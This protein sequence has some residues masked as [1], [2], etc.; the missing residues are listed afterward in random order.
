MINTNLQQKIEILNNHKCFAS[1]DSIKELKRFMSW[2]V[3]AVWDF[4][5]LLKRLQRDFTCV[6]IPWI[7]SGNPDMGRLISEIAIEEEFDVFSK[8]KHLSHFEIYLKGMKEIGADTSFIEEFILHI[9]NKI[10]TSEAL[11]LSNTPKGVQDFVNFSINTAMNEPT[12]AVIGAFFYGREH[13]IPDMFTAL[14]KNY[15][16]KDE[17]CPTFVYYLE[18]HI[19]LDGGE[20]GHGSM[21]EKMIKSLY[22]NDEQKMS[23]LLKF[24]EKALD[25]RIKLFDDFLATR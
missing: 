11:V 10:K 7:P 25:A 6:D 15:G 14:L 24:A 9:K 3:F 17:D 8:N 16:L 1:I 13:I 5:T 22:F 23:N 20:D 12:E 21:A 19:E 4:M 2:H 18:R